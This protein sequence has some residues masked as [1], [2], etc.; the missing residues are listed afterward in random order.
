VLPLNRALKNLVKAGATAEQAVRAATL[1]PARVL[2]LESSVGQ[3]RVGRS[4][5]V[6][7]VDREWEV[8]LCLVRGVV[9]H[10]REGVAIPS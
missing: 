6:V 2:G 8:E 9:G 3:L 1:N 4:G 10:A 7:L 5:D